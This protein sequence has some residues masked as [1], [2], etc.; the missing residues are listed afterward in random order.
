[1]PNDPDTLRAL[2]DAQ[3]W[4]SSYEYI[5]TDDA[6]ATIVFAAD[7]LK[8]YDQL[9]ETS[10]ASLDD[11]LRRFE[12]ATFHAG[13]FVWIDRGTESLELFQ[14]LTDEISVLVRENPNSEKI[15]IQE[16]GFYADYAQTTHRHH[17]FTEGDIAS[18]L[19]FFDLSVEKYR[20]IIDRSDY[21]RFYK[22][23]LALNLL[24]SSELHSELGN[25]EDSLNALD[26]A[27]SIL[28]P[29]TEIDPDNRAVENYLVAVKWQKFIDFSK[30]ER[31][32][33]AINLSS[34]VLDIKR[35]AAEDNPTDV[36]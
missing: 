36:G 19:P 9:L 18:A 29:L 23:N 35:T 21:T 5:V 34:W 25:Y 13:A 26:E 12:I 27:E 10:A 16:A 7:A 20:A 17:A 8:A 2:G 6:E 14:Q 30:S 31:H 32:D 33:E 24:R 3:F 28:L 4:R 22:P 1:M 15:L 11:R